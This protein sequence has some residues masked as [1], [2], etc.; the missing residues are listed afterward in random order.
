MARSLCGS[1]YYNHSSN[2][3]LNNFQK[4]RNGSVVKPGRNG[5]SY[6]YINVPE[7][8]LSRAD[9]FVAEHRLVAW[10]AG[11][12]VNPKDQVHHKNGNGLDNSLENLEVLSAADHRREH[13]SSEGTTNQYGWHKPRSLVCRLCERPAKNA[14]LCIAHATRL[15][16][17]GD[18][19][20][21]H[22]VSSKTIEPYRLI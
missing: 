9:G 4:Q 20:T 5:N 21:V 3:T 17:Y 22:R 10:N 14:D 13:S 8:P 12:L 11:L 19:L 1:C 18:P 7:H 16:R 2:G 6:R 15:N